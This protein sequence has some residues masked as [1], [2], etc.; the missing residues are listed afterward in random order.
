M[1]VI[2]ESWL[3]ITGPTS[4]NLS[5]LALINYRPPLVWLYSISLQPVIIA[6]LIRHVSSY[7]SVYDTRS[8]TT[9][10][11]TFYQE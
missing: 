3:Y 4:E 5:K 1:R 9:D 2:D 10:L 11:K 8:L 6:L 7:S